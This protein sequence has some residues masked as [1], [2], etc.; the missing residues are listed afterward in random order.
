[1]KITQ[2][3]IRNFRQHRNI[4]IDLTSDQCD[5]VVIKGNNG[6]GKTNFLRALKW[7]IYGDIDLPS[8]KLEQRLLSNSVFNSMKN[9][10]YEETLVSLELT[11]ENGEIV[12]IERTQSFK[13]T[14]DVAAAHGVSEIKIL[15]RRDVK[16]GY[17]VEPNPASWIENNLP[18]RFRPYFLFDGE[19]LNKFLQ[20]S[21][22]PKI[23]SAIQ[24]VAKIDVLNR[25]QE[26]LGSASVQLNQKA[27]RLPGV[28]GERLATALGET[29][30]KILKQET[31]ISELE[32]RYQNA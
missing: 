7:A 4:D 27:M 31:D 17:E 29:Q 20:E 5:F 25:I 6:A 18:K 22:A 23:R 30:E 11:R 28:D 21:D 15:I 8:E 1:M 32:I 16:D 26:Q 14:D 10:D 12:T 3:K 2:I 19:Q 13:R 24:E 9:E